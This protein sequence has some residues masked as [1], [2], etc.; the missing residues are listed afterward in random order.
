MNITPA[1]ILTRIQSEATQYSERELHEQYD[2]MMD[3]CCEEVK[4]G[5]LRYAPSNALKAVDPTAYRCG[6]VDWLD[7]ERERIVEIA[8]DYYDRDSVEKA[9]DELEAEIEA[10]ENLEIDLEN[11]EM[12]AALEVIKAWRKA[13]L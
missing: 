1:E 13:N 2:N 6:F 8:G 7:S 5:S 10:E 11:Q 4:I 3:E 9:L 12:D